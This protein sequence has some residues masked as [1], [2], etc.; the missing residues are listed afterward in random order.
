MSVLRVNLTMSCSKLS[1]ILS[2][3]IFDFHVFFG[4]LHAPEGPTA[5]SILQQVFR[6]Q[7]NMR[8]DGVL[9]WS[10]FGA[11]TEANFTSLCP[12]G[13]QWVWE[14][15][16]ECAQDARDMASIFLGLLSILFFMVSSVP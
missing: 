5:L 11:A 13:S 3:Y 14:G 9:A 7:Q 2:K 16:G 12:N 10:S 15:L 6:P 1:F 8:T 4:S